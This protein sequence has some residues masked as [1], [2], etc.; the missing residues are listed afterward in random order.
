MTGH[1]LFHSSLNLPVTV[2]FK[3]KN[4]CITDI[5]Y[6]CLATKKTVQDCMGVSGSFLAKYGVI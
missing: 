5:K 6:T 4:N 2:Y 3:I 1:K